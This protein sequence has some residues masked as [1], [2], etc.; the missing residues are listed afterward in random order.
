MRGRVSEGVGV[1][2]GGLLGCGGK[3]D[4]DE[5]V[6]ERRLYTVKANEGKRTED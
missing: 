3:W 6:R 1:G 4:S 2:G 5:S